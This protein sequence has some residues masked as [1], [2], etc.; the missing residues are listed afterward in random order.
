M[1]A[2]KIKFY[3]LFLFLWVI[4]AHPEPDPDPNC[5]SYPEPGTPLNPGPIRIWIHKIGWK[6]PEDK[7]SNMYVPI[8]NICTQISYLCSS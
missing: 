2:S 8:F 4:F 6:V 5:K 7:I 1:S 3:Q